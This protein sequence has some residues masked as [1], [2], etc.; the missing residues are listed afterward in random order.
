MDANDDFLTIDIWT[1]ISNKIQ[2]F[3]RTLFSVQ[4]VDA[5]LLF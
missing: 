4:V 2:S 5:G 1:K 3:F